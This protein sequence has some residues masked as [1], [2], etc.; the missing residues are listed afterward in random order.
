M[1]ASKILEKAF[2]EWLENEKGKGSEGLV[3]K[4]SIEF[5]MSLLRDVHFRDLHPCNFN[6]TYYYKGI[7]LVPDDSISTDYEFVRESNG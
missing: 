7:K 3:I 2:Y 4:V 6:Q 5:Y 1:D